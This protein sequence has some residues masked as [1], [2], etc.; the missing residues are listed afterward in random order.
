MTWEEYK[1]EALKTWNKD[2]FTEEQAFEYIIMKLIEEFGEL[3]GSLAK[4][5][6]HGKPNNN[7]EELGDIYWYLAVWESMT[8][9]LLTMGKSCCG[10]LVDEICSCLINL[11]NVRTFEPIKWTNRYLA[12][13]KASVDA[14][15]CNLNLCE[16][17]IWIRNIAKLRLRHGETYNAKHYTG[18]LNG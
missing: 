3:M 5:K 4:E 14:I 10:D 11:I 2:E 6:Y 12:K 16:E 9:G 17:Y 7:L 13:L 15:A 1:L 8:D 18:D